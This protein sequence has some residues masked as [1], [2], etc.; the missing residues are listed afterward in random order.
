MSLYIRIYLDAEKTKYS[1]KKIIF[2]K[3]WE[4]GGM[5]LFS[6]IILEIAK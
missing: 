1:K 4:E 5:F 3:I 2:L 6:Q